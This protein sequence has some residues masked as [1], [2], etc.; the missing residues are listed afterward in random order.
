MSHS[1]GN[2]LGPI[3]GVGYINELLARLTESPVHDNTTHNASL[4]FPLHRALYADF[5]HENAMVAV[6]AAMGL[7]DVESGDGEVP[8]PDKGPQKDREDR[9]WV[10]SNMVPFSGRMVT[11]R[12]ECT[13]G[14]FGH[15][16][17]YG[18]ARNGTYVRILVNDALQPLRFCGGD[19]DALCGLESFV[20]SQGYARRNG[21]G[22]FRKCYN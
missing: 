15:E 18:P 1:R 17:G 19:A 2:P 9:V 6:Y 12:L 7:F 5:S 8:D 20:E 10:A 11:E 22:D 4:P 16:A 13:P 3:Q 14:D 21:D